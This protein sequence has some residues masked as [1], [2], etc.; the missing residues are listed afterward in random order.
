MRMLALMLTPVLGLVIISGCARPNGEVQRLT[1]RPSAE[2]RQLSETKILA[3]ARAAVSTNS[4]HLGYKIESLRVKRER[5]NWKVRI[6]L[7]HPWANS[8]GAMMPM[9]TPLDRLILE[10]NPSTPDDSGE[11]VCVI[12]GGGKLLSYDAYFFP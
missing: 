7:D 10:K 8:L 5:A 2:S 12:S 6:R 4:I 9:I 3:I 11:E 1:S